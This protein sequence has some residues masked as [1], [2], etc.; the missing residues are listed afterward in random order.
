MNFFKNL[1]K[2]NC[3]YIG[4]SS[5][6]QGEFKP[7]PKKEERVEIKKTALTGLIKRVN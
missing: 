2:K 6:K 4:L 5:F 7:E 3:E 1:F